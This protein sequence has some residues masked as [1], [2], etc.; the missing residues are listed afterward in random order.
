MGSHF[1]LDA[2]SVRDGLRIEFC[3]DPAWFQPSCD[4]SIGSLDRFTSARKQGNPRLK[5][6]RDRPQPSLHFIAPRN[7]SKKWKIKWGTS[8]WHQLFQ[9]RMGPEGCPRPQGPWSPSSQCWGAI[10]LMAH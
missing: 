3:V 10:Y 5:Y 7:F 2:N 8:L 6:H 4:H 1:F 9:T